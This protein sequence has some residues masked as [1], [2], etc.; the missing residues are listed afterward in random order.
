MTGE[1]RYIEVTDGMIEAGL[2]ELYDHHILRDNH[3]EIV[4]NIFRMMM[5]RAIIEDQQ[6]L[7]QPV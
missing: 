6:A 3:R 7:K 1:L 4:E 2:E 5:M